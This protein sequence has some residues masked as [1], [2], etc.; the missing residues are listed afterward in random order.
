MNPTLKHD[1]TE[2]LVHQYQGKVNARYINKIECPSC[3]VREAF[4]SVDAPWVIQCG[5]SNKCGASHHV[6][7][8]MPEFFETWTERYQP[9]TDAE[10]QANPT[11]VADG[12]L[13]DGRGFDL[14]RIKGW[15][16]QEYYY[17][18]ELNAGTTTVRFQL[19][20]AYWERLL[21]KP[22]RFGKQK[23]NFVGT[24]KGEVWCPPVLSMTDLIAAQ[25]IWIVEGIF[26]AI[27]LHHAGIVAVSNMSCN[28]YPAKFLATLRKN[29]DHIGQRPRIIWAQDG[30]KAGRTAIVKFAAMARKDQWTCG[31]AQPM[32][33]GRDYDW[34]DLHQLGRL[35]SH[36]IEKYL[37]Y[38]DLVLAETASEKALMMYEYRERQQFW[39][40][41][42]SQLWWWNLD[43][44]AY[45]KAARTFEKDGEKKLTKEDRH[46]ALTA[47]GSVT[48]LSSALPQPLYFQA[49]HITDEHWYYFGIEMP[50]GRFE[51]LKFT[52]KQ[53]ASP[54]E[55]KN[56][57]LSIKG[58]WWTGKP[59]QLERIM[60]DM[61]RN[62][63]TVETVDFIG[64]SKEHQSYLFNE[65]AVRDG[66]V[67]RLN[68]EDYFDFG[69]LSIKS[70]SNAPEL[71]IN[72]VSS[73]YDS[74]WVK[75]LQIA[76]STTG[77]VSL[78]YWLGTLFCEQI[79][80]RHQ[81]FPFFELV[82]E[83]GAGKTTLIEFMWKLY[84]RPDWEGLDPNKMTVA[85]RSRYFNQVSNLPVVL[86]EADR[87]GDGAK[88]YDWDELKPAYNGRPMR[89]RGVK[90]NGNDTDEPPFRGAF[91]ISQNAKVE[92]S[93]AILSRIC[94]ITV[95]RE[96]HTDYSKISSDWL[97]RLPVENASG[98]MLQ[99]L[100]LEK[101]LLALFDAQAAH[102]EAF[103]QGLDEIR[104]V[105]IAKNHSQLLAL[106]ECLG[107]NGLQL[108]PETSLQ[109]AR[110]FIV[111]M[112]KERQQAINSEH[113]MVVEFWEA[114]DY[115]EGTHD[116][117]RLNHFG[118]GSQQIAI[119]L[120]EFERFCGELKLRTPEIKLLKPYL[121]GSK[122]RKFLDS[123]KV[124]HSK[125]NQKTIR[126]WVFDNP[127]A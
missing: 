28:N 82:G 75:H 33:S 67:E 42:D 64:Y 60:Q 35:T 51:K 127:D 96:H 29:T 55:F 101:K 31:A 24:Y 123:N 68:E 57:M 13:R 71:N 66:K 48:C 87:E 121:R 99:A 9:K 81:S 46:D 65:I 110:Q 125:I 32:V 70:L 34:N 79:R 12:Y 112:A 72:P 8:L 78:A 20:N 52:P 50:D 2:A 59:H 94:H 25:E 30:N 89:S 6:K 38:G 27:A 39:F 21:D 49:N 118:D 109:P 117:S 119:N 102:Y 17:K 105:R 63:K 120:K 10:I 115:I 44:N 3:H 4:T 103:L 58:A 26:D 22:Q 124:V 83:A 97:S 90:N 53:L 113:P 91:V 80:S 16:T 7:E 77:L 85:A 61:T 86:I 45:E 56:R 93:E 11:A 47:S 106:L 84:G 41:F 104:M 92:A 114:Y 126:C 54:G 74:E 1:I 88:P 98:F 14:I 36:H 95:T 40:T 19:P 62:L 18:Q 100:K 76:F 111:E 108:L 122:S 37:H 23:A 116:D 15:Y 73:E 43:M 69:K 107:E 5:R